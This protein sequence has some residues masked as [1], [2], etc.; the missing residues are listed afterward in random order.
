MGCWA[1]VEPLSGN[2]L[3]EARQVIPEITHRVTLRYGVPAS[4]E[5]VFKWGDRVL[6]IISVI[7]VEE[8]H[9]ELTV[10]CKEIV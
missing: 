4:P 10:A 3:F 5:M 1:H 7:D 8:R 9:R 2:E 6:G